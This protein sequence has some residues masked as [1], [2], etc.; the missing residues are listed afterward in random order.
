[1]TR[2]TTVVALARPEGV[3][4]SAD[5]GTNVF[6]RPITGMQKIRRLRAVDGTPVGLLGISGAGAAFNV[7]RCVF[8]ERPIEPLG[9]QDPEAWSYDIAVLITQAMLEAGL[10]DKETGQIDA[11]MLLGVPGHVWNL[12]HHLAI[13][14]PDGISAVGSGEAVAVGALDALLAHSRMTPEQAVRAAVAIAV[15]RDQWSRLPLQHESLTAGGG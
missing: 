14:A 7:T 9:E 12:D 3:W 8:A 13:R 1:M 11:A 6:D 4:M 2:V 15:E 5:T 10:V